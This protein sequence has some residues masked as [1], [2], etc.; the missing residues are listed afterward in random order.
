MLEILLQNV[1]I[2]LF[3]HQIDKI[4]NRRLGDKFSLQ[5]SGC[6]SNMKKYYVILFLNYH[7]LYHTIYLTISVV[8]LVRHRYFQ[9]YAVANKAI[10]FAN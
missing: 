2:V 4:V 8:M 5:E 10:F 7:V 9:F 6:P 3:S 1:A